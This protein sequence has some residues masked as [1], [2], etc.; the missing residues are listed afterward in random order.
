MSLKNSDQTPTSLADLKDSSGNFR[1]VE[2]IVTYTKKI[3]SNETTTTPAY[4]IFYP[5]YHDIVTESK[6]FNATL[7]S[8]GDAYF[9]IDTDDRMQSMNIEAKYFDEIAGKIAWAYKYLTKFQ[10]RDNGGIQLTIKNSKYAIKV[11]FHQKF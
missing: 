3:S 6:S 4:Q 10:T 1:T 2:V 7:D 11:I 5:S 9:E 8:N